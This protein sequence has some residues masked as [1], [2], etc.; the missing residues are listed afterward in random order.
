MQVP[1]CL[2]LG[3]HAASARAASASNVLPRGEVLGAAADPSG[4]LLGYCCL[5]LLFFTCLGGGTRTANHLEMVHQQHELLLLFPMNPTWCK[6]PHEGSHPSRAKR[7]PHGKDLTCFS[8]Q[9]LKASHVLAN[10]LSLRTNQR[11]EL[12]S[13]GFWRQ[14]GSLAGAWTWTPPALSLH[15]SYCFG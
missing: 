4:Q 1:G 12:I 10:D 11:R 13:D 14:A 9:P 7:Q 15:Q 8:S 2:H 5:C 3:L 6:K